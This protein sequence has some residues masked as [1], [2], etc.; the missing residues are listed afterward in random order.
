MAFSSWMLAAVPVLPMRYTYTVFA[1]PLNIISAA[2]TV[3][4]AL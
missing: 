1:P 3:L 2:S 4:V